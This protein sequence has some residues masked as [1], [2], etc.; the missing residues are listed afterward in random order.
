MLEVSLMLLYYFL[1]IFITIVLF[2]FIIG[3]IESIRFPS[4]IGDNRREYTSTTNNNVMWFKVAT[5][6]LEGFL[7]EVRVARTYFNLEFELFMAHHLAF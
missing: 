3:N 6:Y 5:L 4:Q 1:F 2:L 7:D